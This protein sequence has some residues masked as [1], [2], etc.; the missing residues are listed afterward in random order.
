M[1]Y[2]GGRL[3]DFPPASGYF[4]NLPDVC[5]VDYLTLES[6]EVAEAHGRIA[7]DV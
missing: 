6:S 5:T 3:S 2:L 1:Y 7:D 4:L